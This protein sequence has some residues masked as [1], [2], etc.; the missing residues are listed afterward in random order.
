MTRPRLQAGEAFAW[1]D[2]H[3]NL[4]TG[5][6]PSR[7]RIDTPTLDRART[8]GAAV[9]EISIPWHNVATG[10]FFSTSA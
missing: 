4:E 6:G 5:V 2:S 3:V 8:L 10:F 7:R 1:L 9:S